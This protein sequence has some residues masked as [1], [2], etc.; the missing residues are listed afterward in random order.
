MQ[1]M[2]TDIFSQTQHSEVFAELCCALYEREVT[3]LG[4]SSFDPAR[5]KSRLKSLPFYIQ[6]AAWGLIYSSSELK[7]DIQNASWQAKQ[8]NKP[9]KKT[10]S[11]ALATWID[12]HVAPGLPLPV[13]VSQNDVVTVKLDSVDRIDYEQKRFHL[14]RWGW[15][16]F[17][18]EQL[19]EED[20]TCTVLKPTKTIMGAAA[21]GHCW[22]HQGKLPPVALS[23]RELLLST[24]L[25]WPNFQSV[26]QNTGPLAG[27]FS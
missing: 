12:K 26:R 7:L 27:L 21:A 10:T 17:N 14:N 3:T 16:H 8:S 18:G 2:Q 20:A 6:K 9:P 4:Y 23:L 13:W 24:L 19:Q 11:S 25:D 1:T 5:I 15:F 22:N